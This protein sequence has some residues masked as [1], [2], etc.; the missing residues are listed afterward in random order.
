MNSAKKHKGSTQVVVHGSKMAKD[1]TIVE[2]AAGVTSVAN[3]GTADLGIYPEST[4]ASSVANRPLTVSGLRWS[5]TVQQNITGTSSIGYKWCIWIRRKAQAI[6]MPAY[7]GAGVQ[8]AFGSTDESDILVWGEGRTGQAAQ[9]ADAG[10]HEGATKTQRKMQQGDV[11]V[12]SIRT[13]TTGATDLANVHGIVQT[14][15]KS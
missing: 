15:L 3:A 14:F 13:V 9:G 8:D 10:H 5:F 12:F 7:Q 6:A 2:I 1:K 4:D 11:L